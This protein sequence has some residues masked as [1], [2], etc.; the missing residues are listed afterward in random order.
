MAYDLVVRGGRVIDPAQKI[1]G[2]RDVA[3]RDGRIAA[4]EPSIP[5][6]AASEVVDASGRLVLPGLIDTHA[7]VY[8]YVTGRFGL[9]AD[10]VG[11]HSG[12]TTLVDQGGRA[13]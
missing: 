5:R 7:H 4:V 10:M 9:D 1:D 6:E 8:R 2:I 11:V 13:A 3:I 12:V